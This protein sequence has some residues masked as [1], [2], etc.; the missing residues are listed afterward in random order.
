MVVHP[1]ANR[2]Q[3]R[4]FLCRTGSCCEQKNRTRRIKRGSRAQGWTALEDTAAAGSKA[5]AASFSLLDP[6]GLRKQSGCNTRPIMLCDQMQRS[7][8]SLDV[9]HMCLFSLVFMS[10]S[11]RSSVYSLLYVFNG[12]HELTTFGLFLFPSR[13]PSHRE[14]LNAFEKEQV[15]KKRKSLPQ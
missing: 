4:R 2:N 8:Q 13:G 5:Y 6:S 9:I 12:V 10:S 3:P 7:I 1:S 15:M 14:S 11:L